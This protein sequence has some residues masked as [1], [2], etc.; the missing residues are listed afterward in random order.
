MRLTVLAHGRDIVGTAVVIK[1]AVEVFA[2]LL[3]QQVR[4]LNAANSV[5]QPLD[6][7]R[8][9]GRL[10]ARGSELHGNFPFHGG[11]E[12]RAF[13]RTKCGPIT[14]PPSPFAPRLVD[15]V[16]LFRIALLSMP[17]G[18]RALTRESD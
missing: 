6:N 12:G 13:S 2:L 14:A 10:R 11:C 17:A 5:S 4:I 16:R 18:Q 9:K 8:N 1:I 7:T 3:P 15:D